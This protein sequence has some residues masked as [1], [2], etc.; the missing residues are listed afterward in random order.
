MTDDKR[1]GDGPY[2]IK[3]KNYWWHVD[4]LGEE[5]RINQWAYKIGAE[6]WASKLNAA[7]AEGRKAER[8]RCAMIAEDE[9]IEH[10]NGEESY[11]CGAGELIAKKIRGGQDGE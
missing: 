8:E 3:N 10:N 9:A 2:R 6:W 5:Q 4:G 11:L 7:H 1:A